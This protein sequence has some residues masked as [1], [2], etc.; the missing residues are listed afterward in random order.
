MRKPDES[1]EGQPVDDAPEV[2]LKRAESLARATEI[3]FKPLGHPNVPLKFLLG[4]HSSWY[5]R[6]LGASVGALAMLVAVLVSAIVM[7]INDPLPGLDFAMTESTDIERARPIGF[8]MFSPILPGAAAPLESVRSQARSK[9]A[10]PELRLAS[11]KSRRESR[12][13]PRLSIQKFVPTKLV[14]YAENGVIKKRIE[15]WL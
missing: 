10:K 1:L 3:M 4:Y 13:S 11:Y 8:D 6:F 15:P 12:T 14:I 2:D 7:G 9:L 5:G